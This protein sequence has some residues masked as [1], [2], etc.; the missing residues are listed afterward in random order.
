MKTITVAAVALFAA[1]CGDRAV[2]ASAK[3]DATL[4]FAS[5]ASAPRRPDGAIAVKAAMEK[6]YGGQDADELK[7]TEAFTQLG[8][9]RPLA[10]GLNPAALRRIPTSGRLEAISL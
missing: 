3:P 7:G 9:F 1:G 8:S 4:R 5:P 6:C 2:D 10:C